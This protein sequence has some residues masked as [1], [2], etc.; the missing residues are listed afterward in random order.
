VEKVVIVILVLY[1][2]AKIYMISIMKTVDIDREILVVLEME[3][4]V[5]MQAMEV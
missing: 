3:E 1:M 2:K 5:E 4:M